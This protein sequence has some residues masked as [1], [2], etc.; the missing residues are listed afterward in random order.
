MSLEDVLI[1]S[2]ARLRSTRASTLER[3]HYV[4]RKQLQHARDHFVC[5]SM[6]S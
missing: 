3:P 2:A 6:S 4:K 5:T 1:A